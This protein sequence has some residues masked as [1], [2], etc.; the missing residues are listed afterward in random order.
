[1]MVTFREMQ[2]INQSECL[3]ATTIIHDQPLRFSDGALCSTSEYE[4]F[5][6]T[7]G[8]RGVVNAD[9]QYGP[10][11][12][13]VDH[14]LYSLIKS[15]HRDI[16]A[17]CQK[18]DLDRLNT[19]CQNAGYRGSDL[20]NIHALEPNQKP[21]YQSIYDLILVQSDRKIALFTNLISLESLTEQGRLILQYAPKIL[22]LLRLRGDADTLEWLVSQLDPNNDNHFMKTSEDKKEWYD[23]A[24][25][26]KRFVTYTRLMVADPSKSLT[27]GQINQF[28]SLGFSHPQDLALNLIKHK[29]HECLRDYILEWNRRTTSSITSQAML[30]MINESLQ[31]ERFNIDAFLCLK[32]D[33]K[34]TTAFFP[35]IISKGV[36]QS[37]DHAFDGHSLRPED[38][39]SLE[40]C[41]DNI[42]IPFLKTAYKAIKSGNIACLFTKR[43]PVAL[44]DC[45]TLTHARL[46][47][48]TNRNRSVATMLTYS[49]NGISVLKT[50]LNLLDA[51]I[52]L[53]EDA[54]GYSLL[55]KLIQ[56]KHHPLLME[57]FPLIKTIDPIIIAQKVV[58]LLLCPISQD[59][60]DYVIKLIDE[61]CLDMSSTWY[62]ELTREVPTACIKSA[63]YI[64]DHILSD[65]PGINMVQSHYMPLFE[66]VMSYPI[67]H[68]QH[69]KIKALISIRPELFKN[70]FT[71]NNTILRLMINSDQGLRFIE[72]HWLSPCCITPEAINEID[73]EGVSV[74]LLL[75]QSTL[76]LK[77]LLKLIQ[78]KPEYISREALNYSEFSY[79]NMPLLHLARHAALER[80]ILAILLLHNPHLIAQESLDLINQ[81][82]VEWYGNIR[83][84]L[85]SERDELMCISDSF[86]GRPELLDGYESASDDTYKNKAAQPPEEPEYYYE[87]DLSDHES[88]LTVP[89][90]NEK[91]KSPSL[92]SSDEDRQE[93]RQKVQVL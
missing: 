48:T 62:S 67:E 23:L 80:N 56:K 65:T 90:T 42:N 81:K 51:D 47:A 61:G 9:I 55:K 36:L 8:N 26:N 28:D 11:D 69:E 13:K 63:S 57:L 85:D 40:Y 45:I 70:L 34:L 91:R 22:P 21:V 6:Q 53:K 50:H 4:T 76:G 73:D 71:K 7:F 35:K 3:L 18:G 29:H 25:K 59:Y 84:L 46:K 58:P 86:S 74:L 54:D 16:L 1:M 79:T 31:P 5:K 88:E 60:L 83:E 17:A 24:W 39:L 30:T 20:I 64:L 41:M 2:I 78:S 93:K 14:H 52:L 43:C 66:Q 82:N 12:I 89:V 15:A 49:A 77:I 33:Q 19:L 32:P 75:T 37:Y 44:L 72:K 10:S 27:Q 68:S 38:F 87:S 92:F